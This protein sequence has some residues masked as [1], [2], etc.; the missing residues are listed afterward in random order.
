M[1][2][3]HNENIEEKDKED[4]FTPSTESSKKITEPVV[5]YKK[6][7]PVKKII[8]ITLSFIV[9]TVILLYVAGFVMYL[10]N[11]R[12]PTFD[13]NILISKLEKIQEESKDSSNTPTPTITQNTPTS[14]PTSNTPETSQPSTLAAPKSEE[15]INNVDP[16]Q[17]GKNAGRLFSKSFSNVEEFWRGFN[18]G[19]K[20][21]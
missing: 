11:I 1:S 9:G 14:I 16:Y 15:A 5:I 19:A 10:M 13:P 20:K 6:E 3:D 7:K 12:T 2:T 4:S 8:I 18:E 17:A 21:K